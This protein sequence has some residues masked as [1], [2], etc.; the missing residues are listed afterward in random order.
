MVGGVAS[1]PGH[2]S[3]LPR[4]LGT[5]LGGGGGGGNVAWSQS[6]IFS[7]SLTAISVCESSGCLA[8]NFGPLDFVK[9]M[10]ADK[11]CFGTWSLYWSGE[12]EG[13]EGGG[14]GGRE[15]KGEG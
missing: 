14:G 12:R 1:Y 10:Y 8:F 4:G 5:R 3:L 9:S 2:F 7:P 15:G 11:G 13:Q 6:L